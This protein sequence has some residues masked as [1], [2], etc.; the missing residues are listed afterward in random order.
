MSESAATRPDAD[1]ETP[2]A[3]GWGGVLWSLLGGLACLLMAPLEPNLIEE[4]LMVHVAERMLAGEHLYRDVVSVT[5]PVPYAL[6]AAAFALSGD[7]IIEARAVVVILQALACGAVFGMSR[8]AGAGPWAHLAAACFA[9]APVL[10]FPLLS[11]MFY[12]TVATSLGIVTGYAALRGVRSP[13]WAVGAGVLIAATALSKQTIGAM[14]A[15]SL[16]PAAALCAPA[17]SRRRTALAMG[18]GGAIVAVLTLVYF[19]AEGDLVPFVESMLARP[20]GDVFGLSFIN[21]W[22]PG[23]LS[24]EIRSAASHYLP[25]TLDMLRDGPPSWGWILVTQL[26]YAVPIAALLAAALVR[27]GGALLAGAWIFAGVVLAEATNLVPRADAGHLVFALP[28]AAAYLVTLVATAGFRRRPAGARHG[29]PAFALLAGVLAAGAAVGAGLHRI[30]GPPTWGPRVPLGVVSESKRSPAVPRVIHFL[31]D[32]LEPGEPI[33]VARAE[34]LIYFATRA[35]NPTPFTGALQVWGIRGEQEDVTLAALEG[36][37]FVVMSDV[38]GPLHSYFADQQPRVQA[39]LE[40]HFFVPEAFEGHYRLEDWVIVLERGPDRGPTRIDLLDPALERRLFDRDP[41]GRIRRVDAELRKLG[42][43][44][45]RRPLATRA[46]PSGSG[47]DLDVTLPR[48]ARFQASVGFHRIEETYQ[49]NGTEF[50]LSVRAAGGDGKFREV[51]RWPVWF[52]AH[53]A[54]RAWRPIEADLSNFGGRRVTLRLE[55]R[56]PPD[57]SGFAFWGSPRIVAPGEAPAPPLEGRSSQE[58]SDRA[59]DPS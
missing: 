4:G 30:A 18:A 8:R 33:F 12:T 58:R 43:R 45:N 56:S 55:T 50:S 31:L 42:V 28:V 16:V 9:V 52:D 40:R 22:P 39:Y 46:S 6:V 37:R 26:M 57:V 27:L 24:Q 59:F 25:A 7:T 20:K 51:G 53:T 41:E 21:L 38:D 44:Q 47:I 36:V 5:G 23:A 35:P 48:D 49:P 2:F 10:L 1:L 32:R 34:P 14:L 19:A 3:F 11:T 13:A 15:A 54:G 17:G 29:I